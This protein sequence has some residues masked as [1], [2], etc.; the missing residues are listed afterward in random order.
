MAL[1]KLGNYSIQSWVVFGNIFKLVWDIL[2]V[3]GALIGLHYS[4]RK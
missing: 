4:K 1:R 2:T 3:D